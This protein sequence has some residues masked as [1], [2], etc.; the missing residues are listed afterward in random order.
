MFELWLEGVKGRE[1]GGREEIPSPEG[2]SDTFEIARERFPEL[3][4][5]SVVVWE[6]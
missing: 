2:G 1:G 5:M 4:P 6:P 3:S